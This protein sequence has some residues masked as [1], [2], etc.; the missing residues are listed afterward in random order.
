MMSIFFIYCF[1]IIWQL[2]SWCIISLAL[3]LISHMS[4]LLNPYQI[5]DLR[6]FSH[7]KSYLNCA[8]NFLAW[9]FC[10]FNC[11]YIKKHQSEQ[12]CK[13]FHHSFLM[14]SQSVFTNFNPILKGYK[15]KINFP[16]SSVDKRFSQHHFEPTP[17]LHVFLASLSKVSWIK[18]DYIFILHY[19]IDQ[20]DY[21]YY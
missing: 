17:P 16:S 9:S 14:I 18:M 13:I 8:E 7:F 15:R 1:P 2:F 21:F 6:N 4:W 12:S 11:S 3:S 5:H 19:Y 10:C 20:Q